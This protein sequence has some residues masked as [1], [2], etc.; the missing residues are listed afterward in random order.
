ME[1]IDRSESLNRLCERLESVPWVALDTEFMRT[2]TYYAKLCLVQLATPDW[3]ALVDPLA[4]PITALLQT[5]QRAS[6]LKVIHSARQDLEV[7][8]DLHPTVLAPVFDTQIAAALLGEPDQVGYATLVQKF[9]GETLS[10]LETRTD[11]EQRPLSP[12]QRRYAQDDVTLLVRIFPLLQE[13]LQA[14][15]KTV[16]LTE[17]CQALTD[18]ALYEND[19]AQAYR[20]LKAAR[21]MPARA[22]R[23]VRAL[24]EFRERR[25]KERNLPRAWVMKDELI[26]DLSLNPP[27]NLEALKNRAHL[28]EGLFRQTGEQILQL[29]ENAQANAGAGLWDKPAPLTSTQQQNYEALK[30]AVEAAAAQTQTEPRMLATKQDLLDFLLAHRGRLT[31]G[32]RAELLAGVL[33]SFDKTGPNE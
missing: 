11:W 10:K 3:C 23:I 2:K 28:S 25:A 18:R 5:L 26:F 9:T 33:G 19:P 24:A 1:W 4:L 12:E 20:R 27:A 31:Q 8:F 16:W 6:L 22:Q 7:L 32:W 21:G 13:K 29:I 15:G 30:K 14:Q 17:E